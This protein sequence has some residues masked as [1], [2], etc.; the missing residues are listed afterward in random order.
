[1]KNETENIAWTDKET[2]V[3]NGLQNSKM[4]KP[5][6]C[7]NGDCRQ[8]LIATNK[9]FNGFICPKC[10]YTQDYI[11][12]FMPDNEWFEQA[13]E[14]IKQ[15]GAIIKEQI[16]NGEI[17]MKNSDITPSPWSDEE[18][19]SLNEC[20]QFGY[21]HSFT[22]GGENCNNNLIATNNGWMCKNCDYTQNWAYKWMTNFDWKTA[23]QLI[24]KIFSDE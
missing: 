16:L 14:Q 10:H 2:E 19:K 18:V 20:Q 6:L 5:F 22:C 24:D 23:N 3:I 11:E 8:K 17:T 12:P 7:P 9:E 15:L 21:C 4:L 1:M 13:M